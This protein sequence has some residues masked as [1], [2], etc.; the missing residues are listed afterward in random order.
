MNSNQQVFSKFGLIRLGIKQ[1]KHS[2]AYY[3]L[4]IHSKYNIPTVAAF[5][6]YISQLT[7]FSI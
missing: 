7:C 2:A 5:G 4:V 3:I 1:Q 6:L